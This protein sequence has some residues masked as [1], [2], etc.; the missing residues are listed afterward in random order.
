LFRYQVCGTVVNQ[1]PAV[2]VASLAVAGIVPDGP[3]PPLL[4]SLRLTLM[5]WLPSS[6]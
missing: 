2:R 5:V 3:V 4:E 6:L 1:L